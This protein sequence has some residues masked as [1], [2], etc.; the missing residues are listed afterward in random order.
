MAFR[1]PPL[2]I[3]FTTKLIKYSYETHL[4]KNKNTFITKA[5]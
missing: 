5:L 3:N 2:I 1:Y 4:V